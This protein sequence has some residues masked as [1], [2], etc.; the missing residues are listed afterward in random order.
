[1]KTR[2]KKSKSKTLLIYEMVPDETLFYIV[3][4]L[5]EEAEKLGKL[6]G[7]Y[8]NAMENSAELEE[9]HGWASQWI[10]ELGPMDLEP[11]KPIDA[12]QFETVIHTGFIL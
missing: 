1:M 9:L 5:P 3:K 7:T 2:A 12:S 6:H 8:G 11:G 4:P 10:T